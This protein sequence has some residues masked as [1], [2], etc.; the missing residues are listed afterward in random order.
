MIKEPQRV[1]VV[2]LNKDT[3]IQFKLADAKLIL[4]DVL[5]K[6]RLEK[7]N[8]FK[9]SNPNASVLD[10]ANFGNVNKAISAYSIIVDKIIRLYPGVD[11]D[12]SIFNQLISINNCLTFELGTQ[13]QAEQRATEELA[14]KK[15]S[16]DQLKKYYAYFASYGIN[17]NP[18]MIV[19]A[20]PLGDDKLSCK[21]IK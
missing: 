3:L 19:A 15:L 18:R 13:I 17:I 16:E 21:D 9:E 5:E 12:H 20:L 7:R 6:Q 4:A 14:N 1:N 8:A 10:Y 2:I 11:E